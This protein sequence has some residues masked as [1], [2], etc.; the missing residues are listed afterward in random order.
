MKCDV[1]D[2]GLAALK[3]TPSLEG[4]FLTDTKVTDAGLADFQKS[5]PNVFVSSNSSEKDDEPEDVTERHGIEDFR[6]QDK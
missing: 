2:E 1:T 5:R 4:V 3:G 6:G